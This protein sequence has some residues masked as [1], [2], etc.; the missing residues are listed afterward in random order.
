MIIITFQNHIDLQ[1]Q[2]IH[3]DKNNLKWSLQI[4]N[5]M[6]TGVQVVILNM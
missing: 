3:V 6:Q 2:A 4:Q 5:T 1:S